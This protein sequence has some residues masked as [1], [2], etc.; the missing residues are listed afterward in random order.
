[1][2]YSFYKVLH[3][4]GILGL[5]MSLGG[6]CLQMIAG[7]K[8]SF[9]GRK[10]AMIFHGLG[11]L[12]I[13][14]AGFGLMA[15]IGLVGAGGWPLW[16]WMK[17]VLWFALGGIISLMFRVPRLAYLWWVLALTLGGTAAWVANYKP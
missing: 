15:R 1:M 14:V 16:I 7:N 17:I 6:I 11:L 3:L 4:L 2:S 12:I 5:F 10:W 9:K 13:F 8:A